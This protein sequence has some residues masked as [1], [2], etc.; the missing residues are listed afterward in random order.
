MLGNSKLTAFVAT[1]NPES[2]RIFYES[3]LGLKFLHDDGFALVFDANGT[4]LRIAKVP[5]FSPAPFTVLGWRVDNM[6]EAL[7]GMARHNIAVERYPFLDH[8]LRGVVTFGEGD[9]VA[10]FK[11]PDGNTLS[12]AEMARKP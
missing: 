8:D 5:K 3:K 1:T 12:I 10:W 9:Q 2:A 4:P 6:D 7:A 11:D